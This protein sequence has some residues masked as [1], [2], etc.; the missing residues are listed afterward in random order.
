MLRYLLPVFILA[1]SLSSCVGYQKYEAALADRDKLQ[2]NYND[3]E[4]QLETAQSQNKTLREQKTNLEKDVAETRQDLRTLQ[5]RYNQL[6]K[7]NEDLLKRYDRMLEQNEKMLESSSD[8]RQNL[9]AQLTL[10]EQELDRRERQLRELESEI[11]QRE[12]ETEALR[13]SLVEREAR[14]NELES[15]ITEKDE[16]LKALRERINQA[17]LG[18]SDTDLTVREQNGK[19][20][21]SLSQNLLFPSGSKTINRAGKDAIQKV[22]EVL[23][24]NPDIAITVE[25][26][27]DTDGDAAFNWDLSV[28]RAT[29]VVKVLTADGLDPARI[30]AAGRG[31][32]YPVASNDTAKGKAQ[33]RRTEIILTPKLEALYE[34]IGE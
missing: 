10:K 34:L 6:D 7:A 25:G 2:T 14:V 23:K 31:E 33:N 29:S 19:V 30:T 3:L 5:N 9:M 18:F 21:V 20:Y 28:G 16:K 12:T 4:Q 24:G 32:F 15:A 17:L 1:L 13:K 22:A 27:T 26:H 8:E 11:K